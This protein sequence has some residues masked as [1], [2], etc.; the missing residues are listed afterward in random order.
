MKKYLSITLAAIVVLFASTK[1]FAACES[2]A[3]NYVEQISGQRT[4]DA[5]ELGGGGGQ[6]RPMEREVWVKTENNKTFS[7]FFMKACEVSRHIAW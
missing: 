7:V 6:G 1:A 5:K 3:R 4:I 2:E